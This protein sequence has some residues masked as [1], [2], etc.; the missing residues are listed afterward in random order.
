MKS[1]KL[2]KELC[3]ILLTTGVLAGVISAC[4]CG[5]TPPSRFYVLSSLPPGVAKAS[6]V[7]EYSEAIRIGPVRLPGHLA[8]PQIVTRTSANRIELADF[9]RWAEPLEENFT[10][11]IAANLS[12][13]AGHKGL[14]FSPQIGA[15]D[16]AY[17]IWM[18]VR[19]FDV[20]SAGQ[21]QLDV[22]WRIFRSG[23]DNALLTTR[24]RF[25]AAMA[26]E[27][28]EAKAAALSQVVESFSREIAARLD[29]IL[30]EREGKPPGAPLSGTP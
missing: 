3:S 15:A 12:V 28:F 21:A 29:E 1:E 13:L 9:D 22:T 27:G 7:P 6:E 14:A 30:R 25:S 2:M 4:G 5:S 26:G 24:S 23:S 10:R 11:V 16:V 20:D 8:Q 19:R 17:S 18:D